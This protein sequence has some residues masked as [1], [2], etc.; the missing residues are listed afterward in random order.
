MEILG[1]DLRNSNVNNAVLDGMDASKIPDVV[2]VKKIFD[3]TARQR[4]RMWKLKR[5]V[6][7]GNVVADS[8]SVE[9]DFQVSV[10]VFSDLQFTVLW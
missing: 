1:F 2:L 3:R 6:V 5:L 10:Q 7:G 8:A 9:N 4:R